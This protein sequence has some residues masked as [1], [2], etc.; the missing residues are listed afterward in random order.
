[1]LC[2][3]PFANEEQERMFVCADICEGGICRGQRPIDGDAPER[4][5][6]QR[7]ERRSLKRIL[8]IIF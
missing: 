3:I 4:G 8:Q 6:G 1:M 2:K 5:A 7:F